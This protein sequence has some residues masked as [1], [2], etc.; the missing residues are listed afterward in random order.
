M[1]RTGRRMANFPVSTDSTQSGGQGI[2]EVLIVRPEH[3]RISH[4]AASGDIRDHAG[5]Q[6]IA[7]FT[8]SHSSEG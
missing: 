3:L 7:A 8:I 4:L 1:A 6:S 2:F 5:D